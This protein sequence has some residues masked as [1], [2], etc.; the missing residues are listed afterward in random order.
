MT[1]AG[2]DEPGAAP[3]WRRALR[4]PLVQ[5]GIPA[6]A[7]FGL[8]AAGSDVEAGAPLLRVEPEAI[9]VLVDERELVLGRPLSAEERSELVESFVDEEVLLREALARGLERADGKVR[10]HLVNKMR[11]LLEEESPAPTP[12]QLVAFY[13]EHPELYTTSPT[14][15]FEHVYGATTETDAGAWREALEGGAAPDE[16]GQAFFLGPRLT[17]ITRQELA[18]I[19]GADFAS[20]VWQLPEGG[21]HGPLASARGTHLVHLLE[22]HPS[23]L[24]ARD[25]VAYRLAGDWERA[26]REEAWRRQAAALRADYRI[27]LPEG[28]VRP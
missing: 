5:F 14:V 27:E 2:R 18:A 22:R 20:A 25:E 13:E 21:W 4:E 10:E 24:V 26:W 8:Q 15:S 28:G 17:R 9:E 12:E 23:R 1:T 6:L 11:F 19:L 7:L 3:F 16:L